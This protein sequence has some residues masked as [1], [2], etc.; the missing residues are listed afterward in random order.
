MPAAFLRRK[1]LL[2]L[3]ADGPVAGHLGHWRAGWQESSPSPEQDGGW[4]EMTLRSPASAGVHPLSIGAQWMED[5]EQVSAAPTQ[6]LHGSQL[7][8][9]IASHSWLRCLP[10]AQ[11]GTRVPCVASQASPLAPLL[12]SQGT[13]TALSGTGSPDARLWVPLPLSLPTVTLKTLATGAQG[14]ERSAG[15]LSLEEAALGKVPMRVAHQKGRA[16]QGTGCLQLK[17][18][19]PL[20]ALCVTHQ[21][22]L[23]TEAGAEKRTVHVDFG[24]GNS[25]PSAE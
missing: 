15:D 13:P 20:A 5:D 2:F 16:R 22:L 7:P 6:A 8:D 21:C 25:G 14:N 18:A 11:N 3:C 12:S 10:M 9:H 4:V 24:A 23:C 17:A 1:K 19:P